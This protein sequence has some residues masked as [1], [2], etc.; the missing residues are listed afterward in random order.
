MLT[1]LKSIVGLGQFGDFKWD[2]TLI[3]DF[4]KFNVFYGWNGSGKSTLSKAFELL[5]REVAR[6]GAPKVEAISE[7]GDLHGPSPAPIKH[8][9]VFNSDFVSDNIDWNSKAKSILFV[10]KEKIAERDR[11]SVIDALM[12]E[13][14]GK[15]DLLK[16]KVAKAKDEH[17]KFLSA[18]AAVIKKRFQQISTDDRKYFN[19][20]KNDLRSFLENQEPIQT[21]DEDISSLR[22]IAIATSLPQC[23]P[24]PTQSN[25]LFIE[26]EEKINNLR[27]QTITAKVIDRLRDSP[28][29]NK[30]V[31]DG[32]GLHKGVCVCEF[33]GSTLTQGRIDTLNSHF[34][35]QYDLFM[36]SAHLLAAQIDGLTIF[37]G[38]Q[39]HSTIFEPL[40]EE[41]RKHFDALLASLTPVDSV[42]AEMKK[43]LQE[44]IDNPF[45][46]L[47]TRSVDA[48]TPLSVIN[49][50]VDSLNVIIY[51]HNQ[52]SVGLKDKQTEARKRLESAFVFD[53]ATNY[54]FKRK[55]ADI[56]I[57]EQS[58]LE[59]NQ[60]ISP[61]ITDRSRLA[62]SLFSESIA[63][64]EFN[65]AL[66][67]FLGHREIELHF[68]EREGGYLIKRTRD[69]TTAKSLSEGE[70]NAIALIYFAIKTSENNNQKRDTI[71]VIDDPV[72]S[73]DSQFTF[74]AY[75]FIK[76]HF[77]SCHQMF[78]LS[79]NFAF[80]RLLHD[81]L[82]GKN[83][84]DEPEKSRFYTVIS[85][86]HG[87]ARTSRFENARDTLLGYASEY[88]YAISRLINFSERADLTH[89]DWMLAGNLARKSIE[90]FAS[91][92]F[93]K[94]RQ[95]FSQLFDQL[96]DDQVIRNRVYK[97]INHF[98]HLQRINFDQ[99]H[100]DIL[101]AEGPTAL[102][103]VLRIIY[104][105][106]KNH[107]TELYETAEKSLP[108]W[109][110]DA[111]PTTAISA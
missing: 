24:L 85:E 108:T 32:I 39:P 91:F 72:S 27:S 65:R 62:A 75:A 12:V 45:A 41:Y 36:K 61:L 78:I 44:K 30:W 34:S 15:A 53:V 14:Q 83:K 68:N 79:H 76:E 86:G 5:I 92:K 90:C 25:K 28:Q 89:D 48:S 16:G 102:K 56:A 22:K 58:L 71:I 93:P 106:D 80:F 29:V 101:L 46:S 50:A 2:G 11:L 7:T 66:S 23:D 97:F 51:E 19:Y 94:R 54:D 96:V 42:K 104:R 99:Q 74:H 100:T 21:A 43:L 13:L 52:M 3:S 6:E 40:R 87:T 77:E 20:N 17:E 95:N 111:Q 8:L 64:S 70:R 84:R 63:A 38:I 47:T 37:K 10:S 4:A 105:L 103:D 67:H 110:E 1:R 98:S 59:T 109:I 69:N 107:C 82:S 60:K 55:L 49:A 33:C 88:L 81:W 57:D 26:I 9:Y 31:Q 18:Q 73:L 35:D